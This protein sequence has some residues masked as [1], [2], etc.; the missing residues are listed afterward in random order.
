MSDTLDRIVP[1]D[2]KNEGIY[3]H[4]AE[5]SDDMPAHIKSALVGATVTV[6]ITNG[7]LALGTWQGRPEREMMASRGKLIHPP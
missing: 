3:R 7:R 1:E 4:D 2:T 5:G 6:P